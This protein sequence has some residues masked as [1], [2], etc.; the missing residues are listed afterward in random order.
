MA[1]FLDFVLGTAA[2]SIR[3]TPLGA[4]A[5]SVAEAA[6]EQKKHRRRRRIITAS[7]LRDLAAIKDV[8]GKTAA[9]QALTLLRR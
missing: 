6:G 3:A 1:G 9:A 4:V 7:Q 2:R 5:S 8:L